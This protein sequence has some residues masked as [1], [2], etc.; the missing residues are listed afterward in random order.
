MPLPLPLEAPWLL[1]PPQVLC[2]SPA[3]G[4]AM[5]GAVVCCA[6][7]VLGLSQCLLVGRGLGM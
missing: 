4:L 7:R 5:Q 3:Q 1:V 2:S 6:L